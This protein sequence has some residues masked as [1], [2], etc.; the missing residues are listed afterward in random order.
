MSQVKIFH[1]ITTIN[2]GGA[3][4]HLLELVSHQVGQGFEVAVAYLKGNGY[5][6]TAFRSLGVQ[7]IDLKMSRYGDIKPIFK[8][9]SLIKEFK[10]SVIHAH[11]PPAE[12]YTRLSLSGISPKALPL[13]ISK[14]NN[15]PFYKGLGHRSV[16]R[17]VAKRA[18]S[19]IAI[20]TA[21]K[22]YIIRELGVLPEKVT[23]IHYGINSA[24]YEYITEDEVRK[25]RQEWSV[26]DGEYLIGT[27]ARLVPQ[28]ALHVLLEGFA[29]Y[30]KTSNRPPKL[31][32]IGTGPLEP[33]LKLLA[34]NLGIQERIIWAGF[35]EDIP[36]VM[37]ALELFTLTSIYEGFGLVLLE[38]MAAAKPVV[39]SYVSAIP[40]IVNDKV[41]GILIPP[42][43]PDCV[44]EAFKLFEINEIRMSFGKAGRDRVKSDFTIKQMVEKTDLVYIN[45]L[46]E[47]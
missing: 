32:L 47:K 27:V 6:S 12:L 11:L 39:A 41:T 21:V 15:E 26:A 16:G 30:L 4:N 36:L 23:T 31:A 7:V 9:R 43:R 14:H 5:W 18:N 19:I 24:P 3:E 46:G 13:L 8:L 45:C 2:R 37:N 28:K 25:L 1:V 33:E 10:P 42:E 20:S 22:D 38:A 34:T 17:W 29:L 40:E 35:R 44:A